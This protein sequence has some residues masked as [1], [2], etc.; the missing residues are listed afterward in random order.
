M[1]KEQQL[2]TDKASNPKKDTMIVLFLGDSVNEYRAHSLTILSDI[3]PICPVCEHYCH[4]HGW[5]KRIVRD[6]EGAQYISVPRVKCVQ[7]NKTHTILPDFLAPHKQYIQH[8][9]EATMQ[10]G[11]EEKTPVEKIPGPQS[12]VTSRRWIRG[13]KTMVAGL[14]GALTSVRARLCPRITDSMLCPIAPTVSGLLSL[15][16]DICKILGI[17]IRYSTILGLVNQILSSDS[18][19]I[20]C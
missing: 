13:L 20:W 18:M 8:I 2:Y 5:S 16:K 3:T 11:V 10:A 4:F 14:V 6:D 12:T 7:C 17:Q 1:V 19:Q 15:C 9:R